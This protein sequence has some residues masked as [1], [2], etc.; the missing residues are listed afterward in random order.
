MHM[1]QLSL[2]TSLYE[3]DNQRIFEARLCRAS[4]ATMLE[5]MA[6]KGTRQQTT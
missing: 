4:L 3:K 6:M 1:G 5:M 2:K